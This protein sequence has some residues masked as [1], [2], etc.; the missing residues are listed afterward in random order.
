MVLRFAAIMG[1]VPQRGTR[2][3]NPAQAR[4]ERSA[5]LRIL[6][7]HQRG[8]PLAFSAPLRETHIRVNPFA[9]PFSEEEERRKWSWA[10]ILGCFGLLMTKIANA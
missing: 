7:N 3:G 6:G 9:I 5:G 2:M 8:D 4:N 10:I 1:S